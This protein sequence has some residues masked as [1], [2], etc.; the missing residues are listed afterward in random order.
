MH[1]AVNRGG[2]GEEFRTVGFNRL[3]RQYPVTF[4]G[5]RHFLEGKFRFKDRGFSD[6]I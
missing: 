5:Y 3:K 2:E 6:K 1:L 4:K